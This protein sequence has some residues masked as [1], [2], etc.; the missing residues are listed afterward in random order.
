MD[1]INNDEKVFSIEFKL[2]I[3]VRDSKSSNSIDA[4]F[5]NSRF[6]PVSVIYKNRHLKRTIMDADIKRT[7][8]KYKN[9]T[10]EINIRKTMK[11]VQ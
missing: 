4:K 10:F 2:I 11:K 6:E 9:N 8:K 3:K 1:L 5:E 7:I